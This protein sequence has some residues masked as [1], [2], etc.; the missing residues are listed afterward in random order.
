M[1]KQLMHAAI[2]G[3]SKNF[4]ASD[5]LFF[6]RF[7]KKTLSKMAAEKNGAQVS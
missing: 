1:F 6:P 5:Y 7:N 2:R 3:D 4:K